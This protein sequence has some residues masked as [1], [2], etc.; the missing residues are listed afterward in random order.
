MPKKE[1]LVT[2]KVEPLMDEKV[3]K[4]ALLND[5]TKSE[6]YRRMIIFYFKNVLET[7]EQY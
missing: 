1:R 3:K 6:Q 5:I 7:T 4:L 2:L